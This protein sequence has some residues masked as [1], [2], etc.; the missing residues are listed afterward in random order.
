MNNGSRNEQRNEMRDRDV[1]QSQWLAHEEHAIK[2]KRI[3]WLLL[4]IYLIL[5]G[6]SEI[7]GI[8]QTYVPT[9]IINLFAVVAGVLFLVACA[10]CC[11]SHSAC[12]HTKTEK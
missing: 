12:C 7:T 11:S 10:K 9:L 8:G 2:A 3:G 4:A 6:L 1:H 5:Q